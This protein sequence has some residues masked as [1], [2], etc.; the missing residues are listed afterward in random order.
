MDSV[1][2]LQWIASGSD[3]AVW[4]ILFV[5][6]KIDRRLLWLENEVAHHKVTLE[7]L[8]SNKANHSNL[9]HGLN[10]PKPTNRP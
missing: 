1:E 10:P 4:G 7:S 2:I 5:L 3:L 8:N 6:W 9:L